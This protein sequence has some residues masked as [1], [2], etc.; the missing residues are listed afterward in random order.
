VRTCQC[1]HVHLRFAL[2]ELLKIQPGLYIQSLFC[3][4]VFIYV[5]AWYE[6]HALNVACKVLPIRQQ[7]TTDGYIATN[8]ALGGRVYTIPTDLH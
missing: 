8:M 6:L 3:A 2:L 4:Y 1:N 5:V 7:S